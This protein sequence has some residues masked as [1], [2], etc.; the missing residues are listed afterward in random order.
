MKTL[1]SFL[2]AVVLCVAGGGVFAQTGQ[3][4]I[5]IDPNQV[6]APRTLGSQI[7][8]IDLGTTIPLFSYGPNGEYT[9]GVNLTVGFDG[10]LRWAA[11]LTG[12]LSLGVDVNGSITFG[13]NA[14]A[15]FQVLLG[16]QIGYFFRFDNFEIPISLTPGLAVLTYKADYTS[17]QFGLKPTVGFYWDATSNWSFG[18]NASYWWMPEY[19]PGPL[20]PASQ[21]RVGNYLTLSL[22]ALYSF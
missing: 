8:S 18:I 17:V 15:F 7:F 2:V 10:A 5:D 11:F 14:D 21:T 6:L 16:P 3:P 19:Y 13:A 9:P 20:P 22:S 1:R 12:N 4:P